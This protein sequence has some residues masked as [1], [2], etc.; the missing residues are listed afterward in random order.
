MASSYSSDLKLEIM[1]TG[2]NSGTWGDITNTN[3]VLLQQSI[4]GYEAVSIAG[5]AGTT[6]LVMSDGA[7]SN[8]RNAV[9]KLTGTITG[10]RVVTIPDGIEK[11]YTIEN[12]TTGAFT[13]E[14]KTVS[15]TGPTWSTTDKGIKILYS[16]GTNILEG[17]SS[18]DTLKVSTFTSTGIDDNATSTAITI[19]SSDRVGIGTNFSRS[20]PSVGIPQLKVEGA[21][22]GA[23]T[24]L[25]VNTASDTTPSTFA[26]LKARGSSVVQNSDEIGRISFNGWDGSEERE[27]T[28]IST[29]IDTFPGT[30]D[31]PGRLVFKTTPNASA[32]PL[33]RMRIGSNG[34]IYFY[35]DTGTTAKFIWE[36]ITERLGIGATPSDVLHLYKSSND[37]IMRIQWDASHAGK[38]SFREGGVE[39]GQIEMHSPTDAVQAG[40]MLI[41]T[42]SS[43][44]AGKAIVFQTDSAERM[45]IDSSG[46]VGVRSSGVTTP[47]YDFN[48]LGEGL[49]LRYWDQSGA[50]H[51]DLVA[52]GNTP[53]GATQDMRF[54][55]NSGGAPGTAT[56]RMRINSSG[57]VGIGTSSPA[58]KLEV[59]KGSAGDIARFTDGVNANTVIKTSGSVTTF[60]PDTANALALQTNNAERMRIDSSGSVRI[61]NTANATYTAQLNIYSPSTLNCG[62]HLRTNTGGAQSQI[63]FGNSNNDSVGSIG[64]SGTSTSF[65]TSSDYRIKE[66][67]NY[68]FDATTR[69]KQ[70]KPAR[71]NFIADANTTVDGFLAHE[72]QDI[73]PEAITG[74]KDATE[75]K[76]KVVVNANGQ[77]IAENIEQADWETGKIADEDGK[78][79]YPTDSTWEATKVIPVYQ[80]I[81]Q[82]KLVPLLVKT[83]QELEARITALETTN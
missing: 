26:L 10:N 38:I 78:S 12:G 8:A 79:Q 37:T 58:F 75:T 29:F 27:S 40:N 4:A 14:F 45:K 61:N 47:T 18:I 32:T 16:D 50:R 34:D 3:L 72:V 70:L 59:N 71:F 21:N 17:I 20:L 42:T 81:D 82:S 53:A 22:T 80:A 74:S 9:I 56:E 62:I 46:N 69:L 64:T 44:A 77:V 1:V 68:N 13:V 39:T 66:N 33:E 30:A 49:F 65:N 28:S 35:E 7:L 51:A 76:E 23:S 83:I 73:V 24:V 11:T 19:D 63:I 60:G 41:A 54:F 67:V 43:G 6:T 2:E 25:V 57:N 36:A 31:M 5:G 55:T 52:I 15:G 48:T